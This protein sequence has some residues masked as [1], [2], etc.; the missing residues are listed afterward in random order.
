MQY[1]R[2]HI[3]PKN[4]KSTTTKKFYYLEKVHFGG[5]DEVLIMSC[6]WLHQTI[7]CTKTCSIGELYVNMERRKTERLL[8]VCNQWLNVA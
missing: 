4:L 6:V 3:I 2:R 1:L 7:Q 5:D 8:L